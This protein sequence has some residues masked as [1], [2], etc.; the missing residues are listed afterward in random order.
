MHLGAHKRSSWCMAGDLTRLL[1]TL[2]RLEVQEEV[3]HF[4]PCLEYY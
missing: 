4:F 3:T 1:T 2:K